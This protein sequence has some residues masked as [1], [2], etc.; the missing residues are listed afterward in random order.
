MYSCDVFN[1]ISQNS[2]PAVV[3]KYMVIP[4]L[5]IWGHMDMHMKQLYNDK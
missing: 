1:Y 4:W 5:S 3:G 2:N